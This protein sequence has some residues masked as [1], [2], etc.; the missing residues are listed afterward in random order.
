[1]QISQLS[2]NNQISLTQVRTT[3]IFPKGTSLSLPF[4]FTSCKY[5]LDSS[6]FRTHSLVLG[7]QT[8][9]LQFA[10]GTYISANI[11]MSYVL[12]C[13]NI[14]PNIAPLEPTHSSHRILGQ[15][16]EQS[17]AGSSAMLQARCWTG[18][19]SHLTFQVKNSLPCP[20][21]GGQHPVPCRLLD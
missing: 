7:I 13:N 14:P 6:I 9:Y 2:R 20:R 12:L 18:L 8:K 11:C 1:M 19:H 16:C 4:F 17:L 15:E 10:I 5:L 3:G 21:G